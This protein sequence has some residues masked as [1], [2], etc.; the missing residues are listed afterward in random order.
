MGY[1]NLN[2]LHIR[3][4]SICR[5]VFLLLPTALLAAFALSGCVSSTENL[6]A[7]PS[8]LSFGNVAI[9]SS[10]NQ[11][12]T[13]RNSGTAAF[14]ITKA[15][16]SG[17]GFAV[18]GPPL[19]LTLAE[20]QSATFMARFAPSAIGESSGS[21]LITKSQVSAPQLAGS[22]TLSITTEQKTITMAGTG[23]HVAPSIT[24]Q[25]AS[26]T[27][28]AG[29]PATFSLAASG[30]A[31]LSYQWQKNGIAISGA[32]SLTY[33]IPA[34]AKSDSGSQF[35]VIVS[36]SSA[37]VTSDAAMLTVTMPLQITTSN[38][39]SGQ[40]QSTYQAS[41][42]VSGGIAPY[43]WSLSSGSL[44]PGLSLTA[45]SGAITG[46]STQSGNFS[47]TVQ[48]IDSSAQPETGSKAFSLS[49]A[50]SSSNLQITTS[51]LPQAST[52]AVYLQTLQ[53]TGGTPGYT[54][55]IVSGQLPAGLSLM[56]TTGEITGTASTAGQSSFTLQ[57][58][59]S[60]A[61]PATSSQALKLTVISRMALDQYGGRTDITCTATG[62]VHTQKI[63]N[64]WW[65]CTPLGNVFFMTGVEEVIGPDSTYNTVALAKY[66]TTDMWT[67]QTNSAVAILGF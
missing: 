64:R 52:S 50:A 56:A 27:V 16:A 2:H 5:T 12:L 40:I 42:A 51:S 8:G 38:L 67:I 65:L 48:V 6:A 31:P 34:A 11:S 33:T 58:K 23:V 10:S 43:V 17:G 35:T 62:E 14:T 1:H 39:P 54:W 20:G 44:P 47:F 46:N 28:T 24:T 55:S 13:L 45:S 15:V 26:Q 63:G 41:L 60:A 66:G 4:V 22:S 29:Q 19:P 30:A 61:N 21:L 59:D 25:P 3:I 57:V 32:T 49:V 18:T 53:A 9:G 37:S 36:N 7:T